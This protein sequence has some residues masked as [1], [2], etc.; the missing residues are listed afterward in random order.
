MGYLSQFRQTSLSPTS[1]LPVNDNVATEAPFD[2]I[3]YKHIHLIS[4][5]Y[6]KFLDIRHGITNT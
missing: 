3:I 5:Q 6:K 2:C 4:I 1:S